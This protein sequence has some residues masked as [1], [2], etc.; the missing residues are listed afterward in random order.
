MSAVQILDEILAVFG[1][2]PRVI[3]RCAIV[4]QHQVVVALPPD[5]ERKRLQR[6]PAAIAGWIDHRQGGYMHGFGTLRAGRAHPRLRRVSLL[7][8]A[9]SLARKAWQCEQ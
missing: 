6:S 8:A 4:A 2:D 9:I 1:D 5:Q 7:A 3:A